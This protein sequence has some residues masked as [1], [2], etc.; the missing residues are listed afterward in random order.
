M[1]TINETFT[2]EEYVKIVR[3]K[4]RLKMTWHDFILETVNIIDSFTVKN[5]LK[6]G[7]TKKE[8]EDM[9]NK[10]ENDESIETDIKL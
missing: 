3:T 6:K 2:D 8:M 1:K 9:M 4:N 10:R 7:Y 5:G